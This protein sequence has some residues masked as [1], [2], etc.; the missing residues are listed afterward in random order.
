MEAYK[1]RALVPDMLVKL[2]QGFGRL[3]RA[4]ADTGVCAILDCRANREGAYYRRVLNALPPCRVTSDILD[5][6]PFLR[7]VKP[8]LY[9]TKEA[10]LCKAA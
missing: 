10:P 5:I 2:K 8:Q 6:D 3:I 9:F 4:E 1:N 7:A